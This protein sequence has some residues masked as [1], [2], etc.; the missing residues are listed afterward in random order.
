MRNELFR[1]GALR[2]LNRLLGAC[3]RFLGL[4]IRGNDP[5]LF[6]RREPADEGRL[7]PVL[8]S[9]GSRRRRT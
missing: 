5:S 2:T 3:S 9:V 7:R 4:D 1:I 8:I 6:L